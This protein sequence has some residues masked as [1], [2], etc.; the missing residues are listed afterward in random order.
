MVVLGYVVFPGF[1]GELKKFEDE[2]L[3]GGSEEIFKLFEK[4]R[5]GPKFS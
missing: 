5:F 2:V 1:R 3:E 4:R